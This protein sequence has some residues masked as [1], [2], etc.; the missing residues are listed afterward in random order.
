MKE[1]RSSRLCDY[2]FA[3]NL[4]YFRFFPNLERIKLIDL[5]N[6]APSLGCDAL[7]WHTY[8]FLAGDEFPV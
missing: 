2:V 6:H 1:G 3:E 4:R 7:M 8:D 5:A